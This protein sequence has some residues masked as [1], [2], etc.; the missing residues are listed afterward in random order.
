M[1][2]LTRRA[3]IAAT[4]IGALGGARRVSTARY[5]LLIKGGRVI[6]P[7]SRVDRVADVAIQGGRIRAVRPNIALS[8]AAEV[9]DAGGKLVTPG[10]IDDHVHVGAPELT[11][12]MLLRCTAS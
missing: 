5:D 1:G 6:D 7:A 4:G 9:L 10:L 8:D 12:G 11:P 3:F 2:D